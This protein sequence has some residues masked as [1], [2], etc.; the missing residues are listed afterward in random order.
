MVVFLVIYVY[1]VSC[2]FPHIFSR[3]FLT[4]DLIILPVLEIYSSFKSLLLLRLLCSC[5]YWSKCAESEGDDVNKKKAKWQA[6]EPQASIHVLETLETTK[7]Q[8]LE[9]VVF[10]ED[11]VPAVIDLPAPEPPP[12]VFVE[13]PRLPPPMGQDIVKRLPPELVG[14]LLQVCK[15]ILRLL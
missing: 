1:S 7:Q 4:F 5:L 10:Y 9:R 11:F 15:S 2:V 6:P 8:D 13:E 12:I 14:D 3:L